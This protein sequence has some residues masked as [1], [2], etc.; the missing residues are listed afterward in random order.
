MPSGQTEAKCLYCD[1]IVT[2]QQAE[3]QFNEVKSSKV[4]GVLILAE[5]ARERDDN[6]KAYEY[7]NKSVEID[8][9]CAE[10]WYQ[11]ANCG[12]Y[13]EFDDENEWCNYRSFRMKNNTLEAISAWKMAIKL[14]KNPESM[15]KRVSLEIL[16]IATESIPHFGA[17]RFLQAIQTFSSVDLTEILNDIVYTSIA[18]SFGLELNPISKEIAHLGVTICSSD[19]IRKKAKERVKNEVILR[20]EYDEQFRKAFEYRIK[21]NHAIK[22]IDPNWKEET[23]TPIVKDPDTKNGCFVATACYGD[24]EHPVVQE[25][26]DFRDNCLETSVAGQALVRWYYRWSPPVASLIAKSNAR[27]AIAKT[28]IIVPAIRIVRIINPTKNK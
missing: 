26:R 20:D 8:P 7:Y 19:F 17:A 22:Q 5:M 28:F 12:L 4:G 3:E 27:K 10:A 18:L 11:K 15:K 1:S 6:R 24:Y 13:R 2:L 25:L 23:I 9:L 21:F 14:A 16:N